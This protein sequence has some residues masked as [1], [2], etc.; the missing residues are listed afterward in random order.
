MLFF[1]ETADQISLCVPKIAAL[2]LRLRK[3]AAYTQPAIH[4]DC[5]LTVNYA[6][7][8]EHLHIIQLTR[9]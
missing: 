3:T 5:L 1:C 2:V 8:A 4:S 6:A 7:I 9:M